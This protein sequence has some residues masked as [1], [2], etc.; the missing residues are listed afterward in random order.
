[1][2]KQEI[3]S[4]VDH[5]LLKAD[6]TWDAIRTICDEA[7]QN[8]TASICINPGWVRQAV[9]Y[10][11]GRVPVC[12]VIGFPLGATTTQAKIAET[13]Q[14][15]ADGCEEFDMVINIGRLKSGDVDY[16]R[17]EIR[18]LKETVGNHVLKVIVETCL[19]TQQEKET[20]CNVV[21]E[22]GA[23]YIKTST[24]FST[25]GA[26][27]EDIELFARCCRGRCRIKAAGGIRSVADMERFLE[28][29]A[30]RLGTSSAIR[31]FANEDTQGAY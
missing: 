25:A 12:T 8:H 4:H 13:K 20:M 14:A 21:C 18:A 5:T 6:A 3:L 15:L 27:F 30:D 9:E 22:A 24:G 31:I 2:T 26:T 19:L 16:V 29:G 11:G 23:D 10:L 17:N 28:L 7:V 1:M